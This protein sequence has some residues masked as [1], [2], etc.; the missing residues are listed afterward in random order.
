MRRRRRRSSH[1]H[2]AI[3]TDT[4]SAPLARVPAFVL[5]CLKKVRPDGDVISASDLPFPFSPSCT[6]A[7][8]G[9]YLYSVFM[10]LPGDAASQE[11]RSFF[12]L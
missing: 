3:E 2:G 12:F 9:S 10:I 1:T 8:I 5:L 6:C 11:I 4:V 7:S